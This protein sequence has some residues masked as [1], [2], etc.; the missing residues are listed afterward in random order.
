MIA[1]GTTRSCIIRSISRPPNTLL[2]WSRGFSREAIRRWNFNRRRGRGGW[3]GPVIAILGEFDALPGLSQ[4]AG[5]AEETGRS[6]RRQRPWLRPQ[7]ARCRLDAGGRGSQGLSGGKR[8]EGAR[9]LLRLP[10]RGRRVVQG[11]HGSRR[12]LRRCR[13]CDFLASGRIRWREQSGLPRLQ[14]DRFP[15]Q[16]ASLACVGDAASRTKRPGRRRTDECRCQLH[17]R[18]HAIAPHASIM[19]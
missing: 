16:R 6:I 2:S 10:G 4:V 3:G 12:R 5:V 17:A 11:L 8:A 15:F 13:H 19:R 7:P 18:T 14:R 9:A 1:S